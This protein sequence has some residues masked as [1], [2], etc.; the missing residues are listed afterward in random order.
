MAKIASYRTAVNKTDG[1]SFFV[2]DL[3]GAPVVNTS[4]TGKI[5]VTIPRTSIPCNTSN[6]DVIKSVVGMELPGEIRR[7]EVAPFEFK[8]RNGESLTGKHRWI[9]VA[10]NQQVA[11]AAKVAEEV[12]A[13][14]EDIPVS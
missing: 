10:P 11:Q 12:A 7:I 2:F 3:V 8:G 1:R 13:A 14:V 6:E 9:F 4:S 5:S